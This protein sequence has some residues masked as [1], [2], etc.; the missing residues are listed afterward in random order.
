MESEKIAKR[1]DKKAKPEVA[2]NSLGLIVTDLTDVQR[3]E[4]KVEGGVLVDTVDGAA[5]RSGLRAGDVLLRL[6][7]TDIKD[8]KQFAALLTKLE[9]KKLAVVLVRRGD[10]SQFVPIRPNGR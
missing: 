5:A 6:N 2:T 8:M 3:K 4:L 1:D 7:N 10:A 9:A